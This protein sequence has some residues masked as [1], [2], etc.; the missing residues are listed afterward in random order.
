[1]TPK[2]Q[3]I[4]AYAF[5]FLLAVMF[6]SAGIFKFIPPME[7]LD[8][9]ALWEVDPTFMKVIGA[10]E[11]LG[12]IALFIPKLRTYAII[13]LS[14]VMLGVLYTLI[15]HND[16]QNINGSIFALIMMVLLFLFRRKPEAEDI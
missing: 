5:T 16:F 6:L 14:L 9:W 1:M 13:G 8:Q 3:N 2:M 7:M 15:T 4:I 11:V 12:A 10:A